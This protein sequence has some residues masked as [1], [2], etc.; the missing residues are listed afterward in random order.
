MGRFSKNIE[1]YVLAELSKAENA[2]ANGDHVTAF[3]HLENAHVLGQ[4]STY[5]HV[6]VHWL[7]LLWG[8]RRWDAAEVFGQIVRILGAAALTS[9]KG[10]PIGNTGGG[11]VSPV[12]P[13]PISEEH[14]EII[15]K[16]R[17]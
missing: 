5:W 7:M 15:A 1:P 14:T 4:E 13:M 11:N 8:I 3:R 6:R 9:I 10:V 12:K 2:S 17:D 16:A